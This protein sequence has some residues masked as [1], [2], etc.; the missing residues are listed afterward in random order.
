MIVKCLVFEMKFQKVCHNF[1]ICMPIG[2]VHQKCY[3]PDCRHFI[4]PPID[5]P[6]SVLEI[7]ENECKNSNNELYL[8]ENESFNLKLIENTK[9]VENEIVKTIK[10]ME[11]LSIISLK[12][13]IVNTNNNKSYLLEDQSFILKLI[14]NTK[15]VENAF[16]K[17]IKN[18]LICVKRDDLIENMENLSI[19]SFKS[20]IENTNNNKSYLLEDQSFILKLIENTKCVENAFDLIE[21]MENLSIISFKSEIENTNNNK[22]YLLEDESFILK[23]IE[24]TKCVE[25]AL[26]SNVLKRDLNEMFCDDECINQNE[27]ETISPIEKQKQKLDSQ[28]VASNCEIWKKPD[29]C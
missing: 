20:E 13:E 27:S 12:S 3:D 7:N 16:A 29:A 24:N 21:N 19:I 22:S 4:S 25:N 28:N 6:L 5:I 9:C 8:L 23:L 26:M 1:F 17:T 18:K 2:T 14:E 10:N 15:C 11:N